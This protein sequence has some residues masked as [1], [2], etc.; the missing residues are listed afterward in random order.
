MS[1]WQSP[2]LYRL[3]PN[4]EARLI[5]EEAERR[6]K[7]RL[8]QV[9]NQAKNHATAILRDSKL[10]NTME[11]DVLASRLKRHWQMKKHTRLSELE[12]LHCTTMDSIGNSHCLANS[13]EENQNMQKVVAMNN[14]HRA[15]SRHQTA[16]Q[17]LHNENETRNKLQNQRIIFRKSALEVEKARASAIASRTIPIDSV[18]EALQSTSDIGSEI[19]VQNSAISYTF[20]MQGSATVAKATCIHEE[21]DAIQAAVIED[22]LVKQ[23]KELAA[24]ASID[25]CGKAN[26]RFKI[27]LRDELMKQHCGRIMADMHG[28]HQTDRQQKQATVSKIPKFISQLTDGNQRTQQQHHPHPEIGFAGALA[29][30]HPDSSLEL[31]EDLG[32]RMSFHATGSNTT[33]KQ[34]QYRQ[35]QGVDKSDETKADF[36]VPSHALLGQ[37][38]QQQAAVPL[39]VRCMQQPVSQ[40]SL[41]Q[42]CYFSDHAPDSH[43]LCHE[44]VMFANKGVSKNGV[45]YT[46]STV[47]NVG[48]VPITCIPSNKAGKDIGAQHT[49]RPRI[50]CTPIMETNNTGLEDEESITPLCLQQLATSTTIELPQR[51]PVITQVIEQPLHNIALLH[52]L[53]EDY[54]CYVEEWNQHFIAMGLQKVRLLHHGMSSQQQESCDGNRIIEQRGLKPPIAVELYE[55][56]SAERLSQ[57]HLLG[58]RDCFMC[59]ISNYIPKK[60][61]CGIVCYANGKPLP[62]FLDWL[63]AAATPHISDNQSNVVSFHGLSNSINTQSSDKVSQHRLSSI[64]DSNISQHSIENG[65]Q[66]LQENV[67]TIRKLFSIPQ[68]ITS[69][70]MAG[71]STEKKECNSQLV[72]TSI[73][74]S[75]SSDAQEPHLR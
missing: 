14:D 32:K 38:Q 53:R 75:I 57:P 56:Q 17:L 43:Q 35:S 4:E 21:P 67:H 48:E 73:K 29:T 10:R 2:L 13:Q 61:H 72:S 55:K 24:K 9:R 66:L 36:V 12:H 15:R 33:S 71:G 11:V 52:I 54:M 42:L 1:A 59:T 31:L 50:S 58:S 49:K 16:M 5:A 7:C 70:A 63:A 41:S 46:I 27:A 8:L 62:S 26:I 45:G 68:M 34:C 23:Q 3:S 64:T 20:N 51:E 60:P 19:E 30:E 69:S 47:G 65:M 74:S 44:R 37:Q 39:N 25:Q 22:R 40:K 18:K 28:L 6:K